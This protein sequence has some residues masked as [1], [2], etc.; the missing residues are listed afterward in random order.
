M[1]GRLPS[2]NRWSRFLTGTSPRCQRSWLRHPEVEAARVVVLVVL[3]VLFLVV[4]LVVVHV[5]ARAER[6][7]ARSAIVYSGRRTGTYN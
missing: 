1:I 7:R 2:V 5:C 4:L 3:R 6:I